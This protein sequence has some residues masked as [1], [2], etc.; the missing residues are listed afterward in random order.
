MLARLEI[1]LSVLI[2]ALMAG[3]GGSLAGELPRD[4][5][6]STK[7]ERPTVPRV[8]KV[9][10]S[11]GYVMYVLPYQWWQGVDVLIEKRGKGEFNVSRGVY[12]SV[13]S[14]SGEGEADAWPD[15]SANVEA[16]A[17][18]AN[19]GPL[20]SI[21]MHFVPT[22]G[23]RRYRPYCGGEA[24]A[25]ARGRYEGSIRFAGGHGYPAVEA[26]VAQAMPN[27]DL[28]SRCTGGVA[29]G[30]PTLPGAQ[31]QASSIRSNTPAFSAFKNAPKGRTHVGAG[32]SESRRGV[33]MIRFVEATAPPSAFQYSPSLSTAT[34]KL[35]PPFS[36]V[37]SYDA[38][39]DR[40]HRWSGDL[41]VDLL[42]REN[43]SLTH[44]PL[45]GFISPARWIPPHPKK[46]G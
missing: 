16:G 38:E 21:E 22:G 42:G 4:G 2:V 29:E 31:L 12:Y 36:G 43:V 19:F 14:E 41:A 7:A 35:P 15:L 20:G 28:R 24:V 25:F 8:F 40:R 45:R 6:Y 5:Q 33:I 34:V 27:W 32:I 11:K 23:S 46:R 18:S 44:A 17:V 37:G 30:P 9:D 10:L 13:G 26:S 3:A 39:R 1:A